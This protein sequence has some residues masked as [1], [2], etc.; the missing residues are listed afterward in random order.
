MISIDG[1]VVIIIAIIVFLFFA[2]NRL[3]FRPVQSIMDERQQR[4]DGPKKEAAQ[5]LEEHGRQVASLQESLAG[6]RRRAS[7]YKAER[8]GEAVVECDGT[9]EES[10]QKARERLDRQTTLFEEQKR[11]ARTELVSH[12]RALAARIAGHFIHG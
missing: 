4:I 5:T 11:K 2:L 10:S 8:R 6:A 7:V 9:V 1:S 3:L 12:I